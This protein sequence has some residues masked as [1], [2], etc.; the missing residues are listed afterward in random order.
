MWKQLLVVCIYVTYPSNRMEID[1]FVDSV[2]MI[3]DQ[4]SEPK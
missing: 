2:N 1:G 4:A 3:N